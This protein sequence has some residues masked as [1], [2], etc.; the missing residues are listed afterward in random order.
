MGP[1]K[2]RPTWSI[3]QTRSDEGGMQGE[4]HHQ[5]SHAAAEAAATAL[6]PLWVGGPCSEPQCLHDEYAVSNV[7]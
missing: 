1:R 6:S 4:A 3:A 7:R 5:A 2:C